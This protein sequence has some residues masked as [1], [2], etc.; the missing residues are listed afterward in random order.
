MEKKVEV[1]LSVLEGLAEYIQFSSATPALFTA[2][3]KE[4]GELGRLVVENR[5]KTEETKTPD[6]VQA[7]G[8]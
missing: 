6:K 1:S 4:I 2:F 5:S 8:G 7:S 3:R